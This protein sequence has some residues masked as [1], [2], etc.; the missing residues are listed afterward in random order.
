M[1]DTPMQEMKIDARITYGLE[2]WMRS[3]EHRNPTATIH[4]VASDLGVSTQ[5]L[6][7]YFKTVLGTSFTQWRKGVRIRDAQAL[8]KAYPRLSTSEI[9]RMVGI[10]DR[11]NFTKRF[12]DIV[13]CKPSVYRKSLSS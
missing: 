5:Q 11:S 9:G 12:E 6:A 7:W 13:G 2:G 8:M 4:D 10:P 1:H 3:M